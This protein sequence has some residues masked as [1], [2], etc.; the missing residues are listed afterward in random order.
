MI[1]TSGDALL[2]PAAVEI[3]RSRL[4]PRA[5]LVTPNMAEAAAL[6]GRPVRNLDEMRAAGSSWRENSGRVFCSKAAISAGERATDLLFDGTAVAEFSAPFVRRRF[7]SWHRLHLFR[8]DRRPSRA[9]RRTR[10]RDRAG[11][12]FCQ[13]RDRRAFRLDD[14]VRR[15]P[16]A[17]SSALAGVA[18]SSE[19]IPDST[20]TGVTHPATMSLRQSG[21]IFLDPDLLFERSQRGGGFRLLLAPAAAFSED[22]IFPDDPHRKSLSCSR[23]CCE[24]SS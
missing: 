24:R 10:R 17:E 18:T 14:F 22:L 3:Y 20:R 7:D 5:T 13:P 8:G 9:R 12:G 15:S 1:A 6:T 23:P 21:I 4:F 2:Q 19:L 11:Q 16:R